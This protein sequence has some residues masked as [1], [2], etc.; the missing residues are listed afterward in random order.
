MSM[1][2]LFFGILLE[3]TFSNIKQAGESWNSLKS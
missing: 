1:K 3:I 2:W